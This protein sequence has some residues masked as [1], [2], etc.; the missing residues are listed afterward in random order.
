MSSEVLTSF[1]GLSVFGVVFGM[2]IPD[3]GCK[4]A[5]RILLTLVIVAALIKVVAGLDIISSLGRAVN[6]PVADVSENDTYGAAGK[7][8]SEFTKAE[9]YRLT[10]EFTGNGPVRADCSVLW[11][12]NQYVLESVEVACR[13]ENPTA[14]QEYLALK[15][16]VDKGKIMVFNVGENTDDNG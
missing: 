11:V 8:I 1:I 6:N 4:N 3:N 9:V 14:V 13:C 7:I 10:E 15:L 2:I 5:L 12:D 16:G